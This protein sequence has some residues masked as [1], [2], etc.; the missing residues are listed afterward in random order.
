MA[1]RRNKNGNYQDPVNFNEQ[2]APEEGYAEYG[3]DYDPENDGYDPEPED[4]QGEPEEQPSMLKRIASGAWKWITRLAP[5]GL[6]YATGFATKSYLVKSGRV[7]A[8]PVTPEIAGSDVPQIPENKT[9]T[10]AFDDGSRIEFH[11]S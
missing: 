3:A 8:A 1:K 5:I 10:V 7:G 2:N 11:E 9:A 6:G 4:D